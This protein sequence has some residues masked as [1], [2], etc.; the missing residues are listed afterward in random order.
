MSNQ[1][2]SWIRTGV[3]MAVGSLI[4][5]LVSLGVEIPA[6]AEEGVTALLVAVVSFLY[7]VLARALEKRWP[8]LGWLLGIPSQPKYPTR[9]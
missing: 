2:V 6:G 3:P 8:Q 9:S 4:A 5:W 1:I 7:Y